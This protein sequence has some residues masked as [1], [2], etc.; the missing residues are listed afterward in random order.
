MPLAPAIVG[1]M[2]YGL[3]A[4]VYGLFSLLLAT[5]W[6]ERTR[7]SYL[8][9]AA[10][11]NTLWA[12]LLGLMCVRGVL[13]IEW[14]LLEALRLALWF[15]FLLGVLRAAGDLRQQSM[16]PWAYG[17]AGTL[18][19]VG[20]VPR[21]FWPAGAFSQPDTLVLLQLCLSILGLLQ[22]EQVIRHTRQSQ[23]WRVKFFWLGLGGLFVYDLFLFSVS[24][25]YRS[26]DADLWLARGYVNAMVVPLLLIGVHRV[27]TWEARLF[28][29]PTVAF[30]TT[31][32]AIAGAYLVVMAF[33][34]FYLRAMGGAWGAV[35]EIVFLV[36]AGVALAVVS[37]SGT[38]RAWLRVVLAKHFFPHKYDYRSEWLGLTRQLA[39]VSSDLPLTERTVEAFVALA[40]ATGGGLWLLQGDAFQPVAGRIWSDLQ[41]RSLDREFAHFLRDREWIVDLT[42]ARLDPTDGGRMPSVPGWLRELPGSWLVVPLI[43]ETDVVGLIVLSDPLLD[44]PLTWED[45]DLLR[46][47]GRQAASYLALDRAAQDLAEAQQFAAFNRF[48]AFLM[49]DLNNLVAQQQLVVQNAAKHRHNP[50]FIDD[51]I[52]TIDHS[53][54][55]MRRLL[56]ELKA[57]RDQGELRRVALASVVAE[58]VRRTGDRQPVPTLQLPED[59]IYVSVSQER[60]ENALLHVIRNAQDATPPEGVVSVQL[61]VVTGYAQVE[62]SDTGAGMEAEFLRN[63][64]F[65][66][67]D[68]TKGVQG[69]GIG[70]FQ[71][72]EFA[73]LS[74]GSVEVD[75]APGAGTRFRLSLPLA[76]PRLIGAGEV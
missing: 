55:R 58:V 32:I 54:K 45:L 69:M 21:S 38:A 40:K 2:G 66:P 51:A 59:E 29:S 19:L 64:L 15:S 52:E 75:S 13:L 34:G 22:L 62:I 49:H 43:Y 50:A 17:G 76:A 37:Y 70:A 57:G 74:G 24:F 42:V 26:L 68:S 36:A 41:P 53:V 25:L 71:V 23:E 8:L 67:F 65:K 33:A 10:L 27:R 5:L 47:A 1:L 61:R 72:R 28:L 48:A 73:R 14:P 12:S 9:P 39:A 56:A 46:T 20:L 60:L 3:A 35:L 30:Y 7:G 31:S 4:A 44:Q 16:R 63:R 11:G 6:R 18:V